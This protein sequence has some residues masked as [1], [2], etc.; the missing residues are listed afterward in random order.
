MTVEPSGLLVAIAEEIAERR[1]SSTPKGPK[2]MLPSSLI[3]PQPL[4]VRRGVL[5]AGPDVNVL[6]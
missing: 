1:A 3:R 4:L 5:A 2:P 6:R